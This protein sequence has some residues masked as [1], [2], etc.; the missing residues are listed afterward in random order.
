[1]ARELSPGELWAKEAAKARRESLE[2]RL[3][4]QIHAMKLP[5]PKRQHRFHPERKWSADFAWP[6]FMVLA[7][8]EGI[9][10]DGGRHQRIAGF[11]RDAEKYAAAQALGWTVLRISPGMVRNG[12]GVRLIDDVLRKVSKAKGWL[13]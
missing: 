2:A 4:Q 11:E 1:M 7:E 3:A 10:H 5:H 8:V 9:T 12:R 13:P 6:E